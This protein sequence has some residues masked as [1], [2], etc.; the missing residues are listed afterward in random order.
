M[1]L[2]EYW[3]STLTGC[4][5]M[6]AAWIG[7]SGSLTTTE[8]GPLGGGLE[9]TAGAEE[10]AE[11]EEEEELELAVE[12]EGAAGWL[13]A[14]DW[15][16]LDCKQK[17]KKRSPQL[18][19]SKQ[20]KGG[21]AELNFQLVVGAVIQSCKIVLSWAKTLPSLSPCLSL[22]LAW[23]PTSGTTCQKKNKENH[24]CSNYLAM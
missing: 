16:C 6:C 11:E 10:F 13:L 7:R 19:A 20:L 23:P 12:G 5:G 17:E 18:F 24:T 21:F 14:A 22:P 2:I 1:Q 3:W 9:A 15:A 8:L 4:P